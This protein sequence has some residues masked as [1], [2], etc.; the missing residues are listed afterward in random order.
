MQSTYAQSKTKTFYTALLLFLVSLS[1]DALAEDVWQ[2]NL[3][4]KEKVTVFAQEKGKFVS[5]YLSVG[6]MPKLLL[7]KV[8]KT[9]KIDKKKIKGFIQI[10]DIN[11]S[12]Q[13]VLFRLAINSLASGT[14]RGECG[15]GIEE[16]L[17]IVGIN[18]SVNV[19]ST[20]HR[21]TLESCL[22]NFVLDD[23]ADSVQLVYNKE[24]TETS[25]RINYGTYPGWELPITAVYS[26]DGDFF[27]FEQRKQ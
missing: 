4:T 27:N 1:L 7:T 21:L 11:T 24:K 9:Q 19:L 5:Y 12:R 15:A 3:F 10:E 23:E 17:F 13:R 2:Y 25:L 16:Y 22:S 18:E 14:G 8:Y 6:T 26:L 20:L